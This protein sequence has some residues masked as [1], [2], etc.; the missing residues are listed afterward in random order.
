MLLLLFYSILIIQISD[1]LFLFLWAFPAPLPRQQHHH[2]AHAHTHAFSD[3]GQS[4]PMQTSHNPKILGHDA[5]CTWRL[6]QP[7]SGIPHPRPLIALFRPKWRR[8]PNVWCIARVGEGREART[9][10]PPGA[11]GTCL[12]RPRT[13]QLLQANM[14]VRP[15]VLS[16]FRP[17]SSVSITVWAPLPNSHTLAT[18][19]T[20]PDLV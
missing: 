15:N 1:S 6:Q 2:H 3:L 17:F 11:I 5:P 19:R 10:F 8:K 7:I 12:S 13:Q 16:Q 20:A 4:G 18:V 9:S 14:V